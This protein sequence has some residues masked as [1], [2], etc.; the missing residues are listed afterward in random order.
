MSKLDVLLSTDNTFDI[1]EWIGPLGIFSSVTDGICNFLRSA[2]RVRPQSEER[3]SSRDHVV[4]IDGLN[5]D[6]S[7]LIMTT[8]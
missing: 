2:T 7:W 6:F 4:A 1:Q 8:S 5:S 3:I